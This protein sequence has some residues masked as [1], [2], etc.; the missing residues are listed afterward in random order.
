MILK[1]INTIKGHIQ[2][3]LK[4]PHPTLLT[5]CITAAITVV[6]VGIFYIADTGMMG[7]DDAEAA[8][9]LKPKDGGDGGE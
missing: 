9:K 4:V 8:K 5:L 2:S 1:I 6:I 3:N 7:I